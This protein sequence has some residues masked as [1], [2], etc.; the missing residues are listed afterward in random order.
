[1]S[2]KTRILFCT[3]GILLRRMEEGPEGESV[4]GGIDDVSHIIVDEVHERSL[5]SD[6]LVMGLK[7][8]LKVR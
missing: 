7:D 3:T 8:L 2:A 5:D 1:M 6:F 4:D